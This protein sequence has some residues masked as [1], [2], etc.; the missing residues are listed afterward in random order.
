MSKVTVPMIVKEMSKGFR[1][2]VAHLQ[3][4]KRPEED[5]GGVDDHCDVEHPDSFLSVGFYF[6]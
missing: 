2:L 3:A 4:Q 6:I 5:G 1:N